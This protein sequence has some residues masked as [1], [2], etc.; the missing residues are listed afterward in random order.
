MLMTRA[1]SPTTRRYWVI[2]GTYESMAFE[3]LIG[4]TECVLGPFGSRED[5]A[6]C[7]RDVSER[8]R[9]Q[10]TVRFTIASEP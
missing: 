6:S 2:G 8:T 4:G 7:W 10:A 9:S 3:R 5:A 1:A